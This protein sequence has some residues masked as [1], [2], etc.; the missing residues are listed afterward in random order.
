MLLTDNDSKI[1][2]AALKLEGLDTFQG[3]IEDDE[4]DMVHRA[5]GILTQESIEIYDA[6]NEYQEHQDIESEQR[7]SNV[8]DQSHL[9]RLYPQ[10]GKRLD[11]Y[12]HYLL[13]QVEE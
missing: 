6:L 8:I 7:L 13:Q 1:W 11:E 12:G 10:E 4:I 3:H 9:S 2:K 5:M